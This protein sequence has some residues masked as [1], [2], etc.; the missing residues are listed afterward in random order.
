M[1]VVKGAHMRVVYKTPSLY[2]SNLAMAMK[3]GR[4]GDIIPLRTLNSK[5]TVYAVITDAKNAEIAL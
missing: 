3:S 4:K 5:K 1:I 2:L